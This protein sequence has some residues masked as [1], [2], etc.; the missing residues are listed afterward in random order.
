MWGVNDFDESAYLPYTN[1]LI[2]LAVSTVLAIDTQHLSLS[3]RTALSAILDGYREGLD[4]KGR[5]FVL[6]GDHP[7]L[8]RWALIALKDP[9]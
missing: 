5:P 2:R 4:R 9:G 1:D 6:E 7:G 8:R 3:P